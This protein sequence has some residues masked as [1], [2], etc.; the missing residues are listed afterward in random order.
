MQPFVRRH[1][2]LLALLGATSLAAC[3]S[4]TVPVAPGDA[5]VVEDRPATTSDATPG[6]D[7]PTALD[8]TPADAPVTLDAPAPLDG[9]GRRDVPATDAPTGMRCRVNSD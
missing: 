5:G 3:G 6:D 8:A 2:F 9:P 4:S 1:G 7:A